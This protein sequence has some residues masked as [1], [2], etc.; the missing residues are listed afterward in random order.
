MRSDALP[1]VP[2]RELTMAAGRTEVKKVPG[3]PRTVTRAETD[4]EMQP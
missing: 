1:S 3:D 4:V 2:G